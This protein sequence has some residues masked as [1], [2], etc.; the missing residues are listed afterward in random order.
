MGVTVVG[1]DSPVYRTPGVLFRN[2]DSEF[3]RLIPPGLD[4]SDDSRALLALDA[5]RDGDLDFLITNV[6]QPVRLLDN[7][8][9]DTGHW[10]EVELRPDEL[11]FGARV[12]A[13]FGG[14]TERRD[15]LAAR[16]YLSGAPPEVHFGLGAA[17]A[18]DQLRIVW[19][20]GSEQIQ[21]HVSA[22]QR[23]V[24]TPVIVAE[25]FID[26]FESGDLTA[27]TVP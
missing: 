1:K 23:L 17:E 10:L 2:T 16:S 21:N 3:E 8:T 25:I 9:A 5:D 26:G 27:W 18:I 20:D 7:V 19:A 11:A 22:D 12:Y 15:V 14:I 24:L 6:D 4:L 13:E